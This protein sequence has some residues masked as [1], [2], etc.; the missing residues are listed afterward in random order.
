[1]TLVRDRLQQPL[2]NE[3]DTFFLPGYAGA[4]TGLF[5]SWPD[6]SEQV[7]QIV[8]DAT[9]AALKMAGTPTFFSQREVSGSTY[10]IAYFID[11]RH[12]TLVLT[13]VDVLR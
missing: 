10:V 4:T 9:S 12:K 5:S 13:D 6:M 7:A 3:I 1:L 2:P 11:W 8:A